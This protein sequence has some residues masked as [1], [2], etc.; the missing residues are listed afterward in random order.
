MS[1]SNDDQHAR[2]IAWTLSDGSSTNSTSTLTT[3]VNVDAR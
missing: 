3:T 1:S 2:T